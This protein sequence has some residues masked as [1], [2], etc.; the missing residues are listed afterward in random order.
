MY[1]V[2]GWVR[3]DNKIKDQ[4][5]ERTDRKFGGGSKPKEKFVEA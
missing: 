1:S 3:E 4:G 5:S 2:I